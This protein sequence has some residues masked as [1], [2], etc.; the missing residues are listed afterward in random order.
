MMPLI[1]TYIFTLL[2]LGRLKGALM[3]LTNKQKKTAKLRI[4]IYRWAG[5]DVNIKHVREAASLLISHFPEAQWLWSHYFGNKMLSKIYLL[6]SPPPPSTLSLSQVAVERSS[7]KRLDSKVKVN[8]LYSGFFGP[9]NHFLAGRL[10]LPKL[11]R[12]N[13]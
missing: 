3:K 5:V 10:F 2:V 11:Q 4:M 7:L 1:D 12:V 8:F 13:L 9:N 6:P